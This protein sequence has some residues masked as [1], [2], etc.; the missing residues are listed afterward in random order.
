MLP[1]TLLSGGNA[2][3]KS[4]VMQALALLNQTMREHEWSSHLVLNGA[5]V[6]LGTAADTIDQVYGRRECEI[7]LFD[8]EST[9]FGWVFAGDR[10]EMSLAVKRAWGE[11]PTFEDWD[12]DDNTGLHRLLPRHVSSHP[13]AERLCRLTFLTAERLGPREQYRLDDPQL[14]SVVGPRGEYTASVLHSGRDY[15]VLRELRDEQ[16]PPTLLRQVE[17]WMAKFFPGFG[18]EI[19]Q[20]RRAN[21]VTLGIRTSRETDFLR[22]GNTGFG[23]T[24]I[25]PIVTAVL[26]ASEGDTIMVENPEIH[27]HPAAQGAIGRFLAQAASAGVQVIVE[28]HSDHVLN[29]IRRAVRTDT[30]SSEN[31]AIY[32]FRPRTETKGDSIPQVES[33]DIDANGNIDNW[34][35]GFF[36]Q[37]DIDMNFF[38]GWS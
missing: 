13:L 29:G 10:S 33:P 21:A 3:G 17:S 4:S 1:L 34:P 38:A 15:P 23:I 20:V 7:C 24:Q 37:I 12:L 8:D 26:S 36:D 18:M 14:T 27:L 28:T 22:P 5:T 9:R 11:A 19:E 31:V 32:Y 30:L 25:L 2:S 35:D 16:T 6:R